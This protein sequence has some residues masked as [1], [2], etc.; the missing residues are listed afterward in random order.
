MEQEAAAAPQPDPMPAPHRPLV[1]EQ[2]GPNRDARSVINNRRHAGH[3]DDVHRVVAR[4]GGTSP[5]L[6]I[7]ECEDTHP[8]HGGRPN[9]RSPSPDGPGPWAFGHRI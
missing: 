6:T 3:D 1:L 9:D 4:A 5:G 7:E 8:R 2:L